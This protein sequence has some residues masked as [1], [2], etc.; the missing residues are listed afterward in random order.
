MKGQGVSALHYIAKPK[1]MSG[2]NS[3]IVRFTLNSSTKIM[4]FDI[5][6]LPHVKGSCQV[7]KNHFFGN[8][9]NNKKTAQ[10]KKKKTFPR[11]KRIR[12]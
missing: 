11:K 8:M 5:F 7:K 3:S 2:G 6:Y 1:G 10:K 4:N 9:Y 12:A